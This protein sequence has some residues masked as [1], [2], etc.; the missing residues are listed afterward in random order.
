MLIWQALPQ[1]TELPSTNDSLK[2]C[3]VDQIAPL[4]SPSLQRAYRRLQPGK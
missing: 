2:N 3:D 1:E 4:G